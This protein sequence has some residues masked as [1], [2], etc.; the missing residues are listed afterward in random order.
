MRIEK[1]T[2]Q[3]IEDVFWESMEVGWASGKA[4]GETNPLLP[5]FKCIPFQ[6]GKFYVLDAYSI[7]L[8]DKSVGFTNIWFDDVLVWAMNYSGGYSKE[9]IP[10]LKQAIQNT[11][12][13][14]EFI[15]G[16]GPESF[17]S[18]T[19][20]TLVYRNEFT[21]NFVKFSGREYVHHD[22]NGHSFVGMHEYSGMVLI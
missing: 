14:R 2:L 16:R 3:D 4:Q 15:G 21:G 18:K 9:V 7:P 11:I 13:S 19:Y 1:V 22:K 10:F 12:S 20:S 17:V 6:L 8:N 5:G